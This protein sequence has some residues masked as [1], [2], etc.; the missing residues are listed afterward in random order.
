MLGA[1][2]APILA[3]V[4]SVGVG[5]VDSSD[6]DDERGGGTSVGRWLGMG[7]GR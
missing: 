5:D 7:D 4:R 3:L 1:G 6:A 2:R